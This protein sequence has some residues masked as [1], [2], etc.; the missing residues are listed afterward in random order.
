MEFGGEEQRA[1]VVEVRPPLRVPVPQ[2]H[3]VDE[4]V[5]KCLSS[6]HLHPT[7]TRALFARATGLALKL[8]GDREH[9]ESRHI[10]YLFPSDFNCFEYFVKHLII[11][12]I[13]KL[14]YIFIMISFI[15]K[16]I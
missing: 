6:S 10:T 1:L 2:V 13:K 12:L 11:C 15:I 4:R 9:V 8:H 16:E 5:L 14:S 7:I 3:M